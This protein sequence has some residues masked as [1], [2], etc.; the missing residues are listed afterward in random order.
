MQNGR[1]NTT[2]DVRSLHFT[3]TV[4]Y[5][6]C[7]EYLRPTTGNTL[8]RVII[9]I[10]MPN[11]RHQNYCDNVGWRFRFVLFPH[12]NSVRWLCFCIIN[13]MKSKVVHKEL[14]ITELNAGSFTMT[15]KSANF[16]RWIVEEPESWKLLMTLLRASRITKPIKWRFYIIS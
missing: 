10:T 2:L 3:W 12:A 15:R 1:F 6:W 14:K 13:F 9:I 16:Y 4:T 8:K 11:C 7:L 5:S